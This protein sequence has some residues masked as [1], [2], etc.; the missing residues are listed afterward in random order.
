MKA[1]QKRG[2][3]H[4]GTIWEQAEAYIN[5]E[6]KKTK[7]GEAIVDETIAGFG[8][9]TDKLTQKGKD[10][11]KAL[12]LDMAAMA[13]AAND[14]DPKT[15][16]QDWKDLSDPKKAEAVREK[17]SGLGLLY[18]YIKEFGGDPAKLDWQIVVAYG[19]A[20]AESYDKRGG[21]Q[22]D[23]KTLDALV[24]ATTMT[25]SEKKE[26]YQ[27]LLAREGYSGAKPKNKIDNRKWKD[28]K[29]R[30]RALDRLLSLRQ[31]EVTVD[32]VAFL[33]RQFYERAV[34]PRLEA[35]G[36]GEHA[37][38]KIEKHP[39][40]RM[41]RTPQK[42]ELVV[43]S[44]KRKPAWPTLSYST[45]NEHTKIGQFLKSLGDTEIDGRKVNVFNYWAGRAVLYEAFYYG[46]RQQ[47]LGMKN[48]EMRLDKGAWFYNFDAIH[49]IEAF[50]G[51]AV[52]D[53]IGQDPRLA[54][55]VSVLYSNGSDLSYAERLG[56]LGEKY[57][58]GRYDKKSKSFNGQLP[59]FIARAVMIQ[60]LF[61]FDPNN[62][63]PNDTREKIINFAKWY[64][65]EVVTDSS[66]KPIEF[67]GKDFVLST[68]PLTMMG[69]ASDLAKK[70]DFK[71][72][73]VDD[74]D[75]DPQNDPYQKDLYWQYCNFYRLAT[76]DKNLRLVYSKLRQQLVL[77]IPEKN[78]EQTI[79]LEAVL[80]QTGE[81]TAFENF[82]YDTETGEY[83]HRKIVFE[84]FKTQLDRHLQLKKERG[85]GLAG[86][87]M[88]DLSMPE[89]YQTLEQ[90]VGKMIQFLEK[91]LDFEFKNNTFDLK[92]SSGPGEVWWTRDLGEVLNIY[93]KNPS[94]PEFAVNQE[95]WEGLLNMSRCLQDIRAW[96]QAFDLTDPAVIASMKDT[97]SLARISKYN[98]EAKDTVEMLRNIVAAT[99]ESLIMLKTTPAM[100]MES[101]TKMKHEFT[102]SLLYHRFYR[103]LAVID[104]IVVKKYVEMQIASVE[105][106]MK[107]AAPGGEVQM[108][109]A[110]E[111]KE[112]IGGRKVGD[113]YKTTL[114]ELKNAHETLK[115]HAGQMGYME[116]LNERIFI[117]ITTGFFENF[118][119]F[120]MS[121]FVREFFAEN[122]NWEMVRK[123]PAQYKL[124][125]QALSQYHN[126][127]I[128]IPT[129]Q[130][131]PGRKLEDGGYA[132]DDVLF[133]DFNH[134]QWHNFIHELDLKN[135]EE[136][137]IAGNLYG[138][139]I[140]VTVTRG[141]KQE[142]AFIYE[143]RRKGGQLMVR[144]QDLGGNRHE[145]WI[146][147][148]N[149]V[150]KFL[151]DETSIGPQAES[152]IGEV[153][154]ERVRLCYDN[155]KHEWY[156]MPGKWEIKPERTGY[157]F[158]PES[159][160]KGS[161]GKV[162][163]T[164]I[165][166]KA[167]TAVLRGTVYLLADQ[168]MIK[169]EA[170]KGEQLFDLSEEALQQEEGGFVKEKELYPW[171]V[172]R[173]DYRNISPDEV[174]EI[175]KLGMNYVITQLEM[176]FGT[177]TRRGGT[178]IAYPQR[179]HYQSPEVKVTG[180]E[181]FSRIGYEMLG[182]LLANIKIQVL[183]KAIGHQFASAYKDVPL[184]EEFI[185]MIMPL[186][187]RVATGE[188][189]GK[190]IKTVEQM[191][192]DMTID[193]WRLMLGSDKARELYGDIL[194]LKMS[195]GRLTNLINLLDARFTD[196]QK[197]AQEETDSNKKRELE[198]K[199]IETKKEREE[200]VEKLARTEEELKEKNKERLREI[201]LELTKTQ[202]TKVRNI[203]LRTV[204]KF[205]NAKITI[206]GTSISFHLLA[207]A[208]TV[209]TA[210]GIGSLA[211]LGE[212]TLL[213]V[214][215]VTL[216]TAAY[217]VFEILL[218]IG[219]AKAAKAI[220]I[221][222][223][224]AGLWNFIG[225]ILK[226]DAL[227]SPE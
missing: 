175:Y 49:D 61:V 195:R 132:L 31:P 198:A 56:I 50:T 109:A 10:G 138:G 197:I 33:E 32:P 102:Q 65:E 72:L 110:K 2:Q 196:L 163:R 219:D 213:S 43:D 173:T 84:N 18:D 113:K 178:S 6:A 140:P 223:E 100:I 150:M 60:K 87:D 74:S 99:P 41:V 167:S 122:L 189:E 66:G 125:R 143:Q 69:F 153:L 124:L 21:G 46:Y 14:N 106:M 208:P 168:P 38:L 206:P 142:K 115:G 215:G 134:T 77:K 97:A 145:Q 11:G 207:I 103:V 201:N 107:A 218:N 5:Q 211:A 154:V 226:R 27:K 81:F 221:E 209:P 91:G 139:L 203:F 44:Q 164:R 80:G 166:T 174:R 51:Y 160:G 86:W 171:V 48:Y 26:L 83:I 185:E 212:Q 9:I 45:V 78:G 96:G 24:S 15:A 128:P 64:N 192:N 19:R 52:M 210:M 159:D 88:K 55:A 1:G 111:I 170:H 13:V 162:R 16:A 104:E 136:N 93:S 53:L 17:N 42:M 36:P 133:G 98:K 28:D 8:I 220:K 119:D 149:Q 199:I 183:R 161:N 39:K 190:D 188:L 75:W 35:M 62:I 179:S 117:L 137:L 121:Q 7:T 172:W 146:P 12:R 71:A 191:I 25:E 30:E 112:V 3:I 193:D 176:G 23:K 67:W 68:L 118:K 156:E 135:R 116:L 63:E 214:F 200:T 144:L 187:E 194:G 4:T 58:F 225:R 101:L 157:Y 95:T 114:T 152:R 141:E 155:K 54:E 82:F 108:G 40:R 59:E 130:F 76:K 20:L 217:V 216:T 227:V 73:A 186:W 182:M 34:R 89:G 126:P 224:K 222:I 79:P 204:N 158:T 165:G 184:R 105:E 127:R 131:L 169:Y 151:I 180:A 92:I 22:I 85:F 94:A 29:E 202:G 181:S 177:E 147:L 47:F 123:Y 148:N 205:R 70:H 129:Y 90:R 37:E 120:F 57:G